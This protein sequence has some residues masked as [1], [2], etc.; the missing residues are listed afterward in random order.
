M[1][2]SH[3]LGAGRTDGRG[4]GRGPMS[5]GSGGGV[6]EAGKRCRELGAGR[7]SGEVRGEVP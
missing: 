6:G 5:W 2:W 4:W 3:E 1:S 7:K